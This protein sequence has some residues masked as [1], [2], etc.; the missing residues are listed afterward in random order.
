MLEVKNI[1][2]GLR[3]WIKDVNTMVAIVLTEDH[4]VESW[5]NSE[6]VVV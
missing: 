1:H 3:A 4:M 2:T 5:Y 6:Y